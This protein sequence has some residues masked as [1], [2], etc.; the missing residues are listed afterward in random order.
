[1]GSEVCGTAMFFCEP[2]LLAQWKPWKHFCPKFNVIVKVFFG[3]SPKS[4]KGLCLW[5]CVGQRPSK[6]R[7]AYSSSKIL[8]DFSARF[9]RRGFFPERIWEP[10]KLKHRCQLLGGFKWVFPKIGEPQNG[11]FIMENPIKMGWFRGTSILRKHPNIYVFTWILREMIQF[12]EHIFQIGWFNHQLVNHLKNFPV[13][14]VHELSNDTHP[15]WLFIGYGGLY[16][17]I[18]WGIK[19]YYDKPSQGSLWNNQYFMESIYPAVFFFRWKIF[20]STSQEI[21][22]HLTRQLREEKQEASSWVQGGPNG[23]K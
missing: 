15:G 7:N 12:D 14:F 19:I 2:K 13:C 1:M 4:S 22:K 16:C 8:P 23:V 9:P 6:E 17:P 5:V 18:I 3:G 11:W 21:Q 10:K 20:A